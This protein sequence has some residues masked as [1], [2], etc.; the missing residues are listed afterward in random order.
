MARVDRTPSLRRA[1][2]SGQWRGKVS[3]GYFP[4]RRPGTC[5]VNCAGVDG[6]GVAQVFVLARD[7]QDVVRGGRPFIAEPAGGGSSTV[8]CRFRHTGF[9]VEHAMVLVGHHLGG[10]GFASMMSSVVVSGD[11][12]STLM[13]WSPTHETMKQAGGAGVAWSGWCSSRPAN[14]ANRSKVEC[15]PMEQNSW[16]KSSMNLAMAR[17]N[18]TS[19]EGSP[20]FF[21]L[22]VA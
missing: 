16:W 10:G 11:G 13:V 8:Q 9:S 7:T 15:S 3:Q 12:K 18:V 2:G 22:D 14:P 6:G 21:P 1:R 20:A 4:L 5:F 19:V 17:L